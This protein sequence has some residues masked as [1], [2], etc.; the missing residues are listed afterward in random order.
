MK[1]TCSSSAIRAT[2]RVEISRPIAQNPSGS[3]SP[4]RSSVPL[5]SNGMRMPSMV[6]TV[7]AYG[8]SA[9]P[10]I[11]SAIRRNSG[12]RSSSAMKSSAVIE[13]ISSSEYPV[14][15]FTARF[16]CTTL[17]SRLKSRKASSSASMA[18]SMNCICSIGASPPG[19]Y[20]ALCFKLDHRFDS[21]SYLE[22]HVSCTNARRM[23]S[24]PHNHQYRRKT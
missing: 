10:V 20:S 13:V 9:F 15:R 21:A 24:N 22:F 2:T 18:A 16:Q 14:I 7:A 12:S 1:C 8:R 17:P 4:S 5:N 3:P 11:A 6:I 23:W 19:Q